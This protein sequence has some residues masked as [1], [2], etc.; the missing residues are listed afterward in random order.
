MKLMATVRV[1]KE[2][3]LESAIKRFKRKCDNENIIGRIRE[4]DFY[5]SPSVKRKRKAKAAARFRDR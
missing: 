3:S 4:K 5:E 2:E 1:G